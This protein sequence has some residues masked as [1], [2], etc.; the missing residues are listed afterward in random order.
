MN[1]KLKRTLKDHCPECRDNLQLRVL[2][3][4]GMNKGV[5]IVIPEEH[6]VCPSCG[7]EKLSEKTNKRKRRLL[8]V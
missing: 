4:K 6:I 5:D 8:E 3:V 1:G 7:Y 2:Y